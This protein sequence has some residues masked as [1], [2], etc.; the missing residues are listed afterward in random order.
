MLEW[1][2]FVTTNVSPLME[3]ARPVFFVQVVLSQRNTSVSA[4]IFSER[5]APIKAGP[6]DTKNRSF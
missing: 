3:R 5:F 4:W 2:S 6:P 1:I